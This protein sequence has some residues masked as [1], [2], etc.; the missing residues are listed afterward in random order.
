MNKWQIICPVVTFLI[1]GIVFG[2]IFSANQHRSFISVA[3][4]TI[5]RDLITSTNSSHLDTLDPDLQDRLSRLLSTPTRV[6][7]VILGDEALPYGDGSACSRLVLTNQTGQALLIRLR[8][9]GGPGIFHIL[10][11]RSIPD[12]R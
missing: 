9:I 4:H 1:A 7:E 2:V 6:A 11:Y 12:H 8:Q 3:S 10:G 5:G